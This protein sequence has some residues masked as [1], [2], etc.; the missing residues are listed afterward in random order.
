M[1][2]IPRGQITLVFYLFRNV[3]YYIYPSEYEKELIVHKTEKQETEIPK[4]K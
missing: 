4:P 3:T 1:F 2:K